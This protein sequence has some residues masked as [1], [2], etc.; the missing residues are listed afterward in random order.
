[1]KQNKLSRGCRYG[2]KCRNTNCQFEH[3]RQ[4]ERKKHGIST[5]GPCRFGNRCTRSS[6]WFDHPPNE[7]MLASSFEI[8]AT[9]TCT[10]ATSASTSVLASINLASKRP[11]QFCSLNEFDER[12]ACGQ[13]SIFES[14]V[15]TATAVRRTMDPSLAVGRY[16]RSAA[17]TFHSAHSRETLE[18]LL[19]HLIQIASTARATNCHPML[20]DQHWNGPW[21]EFLVDRLRACQADATRLFVTSSI[22]LLQWHVHM[23][24]VIIWIRYWMP[25][26]NT[27]MEQTLNTML[28]TAMDHYWTTKYTEQSTIWDDEM[29]FYAAVSRLTQE[30]AIESILLDYQKHRSSTTTTTSLD[31]YPLFQQALQVAASLLREEYLFVFRAPLTILGKCCLAPGLALWR[32]RQCQQYNT[33]FAK[34]ESAIDLD[35][36]LNVSPEEWSPEYVEDWLGL[37]CQ[38]LRDDTF[39]VVFKQVAMLPDPKPTAQDPP[40]TMSREEHWVFGSLWDKKERMGIP[41]ESIETL[42]LHGSMEGTAPL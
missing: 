36:L 11:Y 37:P 19:S 25:R 34:E 42:L 15:D 24:R 33:S 7:S 41:A 13:V 23:A 32:Y 17:G 22:L 27:F 12:Q 6:C 3:T 31:D 9:S 39:M 1:M 28:S 8:V 2:T 38:S 10:A 18:S 40:T 30:K 35:Q 20:L 16:R 14:T 26:P 4:P 21:S 29:M 5:R